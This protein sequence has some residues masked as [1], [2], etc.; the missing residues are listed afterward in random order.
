MDRRGKWFTMIQEGELDIGSLLWVERE[1]R[2]FVSS[3]ATEPTDANIYIE[4]WRGVDGISK[5]D[6]VE[7][8]IPQVAETYYAVASM[9]DGIAD[10]D[11]KIYSWK[12]F[13]YVIGLFELTHYFLLSALLILRSYTN[14]TKL[15]V[16]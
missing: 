13:S 7:T 1:R 6:V 3:V 12:N 14:Q 10:V 15:D 4:R 5:L 8:Q 16:L 2:H 9:I 11:N